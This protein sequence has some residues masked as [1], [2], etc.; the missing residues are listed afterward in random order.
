VDGYVLA[1]TGRNTFQ[2]SDVT[3]PTA[4][5]ALS[6]ASA[7]RNPDNVKALKVFKRQV[8]LLGDVTTEVWENDG[9][10]FAPT[11]GGFYETGIIAP[12]SLVKT[13]TSA[14]WLNS[15][16]RFVEFNGGEPQ[17]VV[18]AY[19]KDISN[20][21][22]VTDCYSY[23]VNMEGKPFV[24]FTF[25]ADNKTFVYNPILKN[26]LEWSYYDS[27]SSSENMFLGGSY[28]YSPTWG[29]HLVGSRE[30]SKI[31]YMSPSYKDDAGNTIRVRKVT[32]HIDFGTNA[33][34]RSRGLSLRL[35]RGEG[36]SSGIEPVLS[37]RWNDDN[38]GWSNEHTVSLGS[39]GD[40]EIVKSIDT[41]GLFRT[42]QYE[43]IVTDSVSVSIGSAEEDI[44]ILG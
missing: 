26:W 22:S 2:W 33:R 4:W 11:P 5:S 13:E 17:A 40:Y 41:R 8:M 42:R 14:M 24:V 27:S 30:D 6:F 28:L 39:L 1:N 38:K 20:L 44:D 7:M 19:D 21:T 25:E 9:T 3:A 35:K 12:N 37:I 34:K 15:Q 18:S 31:Y 10:P 23:Y 16:R 32:G 43:L 36:L 29:K